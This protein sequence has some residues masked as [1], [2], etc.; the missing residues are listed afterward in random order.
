MVL[1]T[2]Q[3]PPVT[4]A[5]DIVTYLQGRGLFGRKTGGDELAYA[6]FMDCGEA[7]DSR[8]RKLYLNTRDELFFCF[9]CGSKGN[10]RT[11]ARAFGDEDLF[12]R[13]PGADPAARRKVLERATE[14]AAEALLGNDAVI[15]YLVEKRGLDPETI[16]A[17]QLGYIP[18]S[19]SLRSQLTG[20]GHH[21]ADIKATGL[22]YENGGDFFS[23]RLAI[24]Y[25][26][27]GSVLQLRGKDIKGKYQTPPGDAVRLY[28][29]DSMTER[30]EAI[31]VEGEFDAMLLEQHLQASGVP[32][33]MNMAVIGVP[34]ARMLKNFVAEFVDLK[35]LYVGF[36]AD[37]TGQKAADEAVRAIGTRARKLEFPA[38]LVKRAEADEIHG[39]DWTDFFVRYGGDYREV[40]DM[41]AQAS[42]RTLLSMRDAGAA[43]RR[44]NS[45]RPGIKTGF[46]ALDALIEPGLKPGQL[47]IPLSRTGTGKSALLCQL[48]YNTR[49]LRHVFFTLE[50]T[51][52]EIWERL[53]RIYLFF[54]PFS[55]DEEVADAYPNLAICELN[56]LTPKE[57]HRILEEYEE[58]FG[59]PADLMSLDYLGYYAHNY[60][61]S[62]YERNSAAVM[63]LK[64]IAKMRKV[65]VIAPHQVNRG[66]A[67]GRPLEI[68]DAR[69]SG[70]IEET[71][72]FLISLHRPDDAVGRE[73]KSTGGA[74][75]AQLLKSRHG[76]RNRIA[77]LRFGRL[78]LVIADA[79]SAIGKQIEDEN[80]LADRGYTWQR[81]HEKR[82]EQAVL[83]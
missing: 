4:P 8:K 83:L 7:A 73:G 21:L 54:N 74:L 35:R 70:V 19:W 75:I 15:Q 68:S 9:V 61:G 22:I 64:A 18:R 52:T 67:D 27:H 5:V 56:A 59:G 46:R 57:I 23:D 82:V 30:S 26:R 55:K 50:Q 38:E 2:V 66:A 45:A 63:D 72:D 34:G 40:G 43:S 80:Y 16:F 13:E 53:R 20:E 71:A 29:L 65:V 76:N 78:S 48:A 47:V 77:P 3:A 1:S 11:I 69:G 12:A 32:R 28:N 6:C 37:D 81:L 51:A 39:L 31:A 33:L 60:Q 42:G 14:F 17:K 58:E 24:P 36:D 79:E 10:F 25:Q 49:K 44:Q 41:I 62:E